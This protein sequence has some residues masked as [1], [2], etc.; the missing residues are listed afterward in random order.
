MRSYP[1]IST[2]D[3]ASKAALCGASQNRRMR[4][5][6]SL[7]RPERIAWAV[8]HSKKRLVDIAQAIGCTQAALSLW[9][10]G[11]TKKF[12]AELL[13][14]FAD[15]CGVRV[16]WLLYGVGEPE[17]RGK[18]STELEQR[19]VAALHSMEQIAPY[20]AEAAVVMLEA[21]AGTGRDPRK[22]N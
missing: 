13:C 9:Q 18:P 3:F 12:D 6:S 4:D 16:M 19:A 14:K 2:L 20:A 10:R 15:V 21:A 22:A 8:T 11:R 17:D 1:S 5:L 7:S